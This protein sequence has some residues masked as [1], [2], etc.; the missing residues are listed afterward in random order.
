MFSELSD[1]DITTLQNFVDSRLP[2]GATLKDKFDFVK[3]AYTDIIFF[4]TMR[5]TM[6]NAAKAKGIESKVFEYEFEYEGTMGLQL[7]LS[8]QMWKIMLKVSSYSLIAH[9]A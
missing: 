5:D 2:K 3:D 6:V 4:G 9:F 7:L 8:G 1:N